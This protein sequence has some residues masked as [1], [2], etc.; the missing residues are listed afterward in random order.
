MD[1][2]ARIA[3]HFE[4]S[5][6]SQQEGSEMLS[7]A[8][9]TAAHCITETLFANGRLIICG[10]D[11]AAWLAQ[12]LASRLIEGFERKRPALA[13]LVL[14]AAIGS[15]V[16]RPNLAWVQGIEALGQAGDCLVMLVGTHT[17]A[18]APIL[19]AAHQREMRVVVLN[20]AED[21]ALSAQLAE[22]DVNICIAQTR[23]ARLLEVQLTAVHALCD[24]IDC[25]LMGDD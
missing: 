23:P 20:N 21:S 22:Q 3:E 18:L 6:R 16:Q 2:S 19:A 1:I 12:Y 10:N 24:G 25:L 9:E 11:A 17:A 8:L 15:D 14:P 13:A 5:A 4:T 7:A